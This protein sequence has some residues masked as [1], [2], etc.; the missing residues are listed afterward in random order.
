MVQSVVRR[1][2]PGTEAGRL[3]VPLQPPALEHRP[4]RLP[5]GEGTNLPARHHG[6]RKF[7]NAHRWAAVS[8]SLFPAVLQQ[9]QT[10]DLPQ[11]THAH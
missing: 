11:D 9:G 6:C 10:E 5:D 4:W 2:H 1:V 7:H 3:P 8:E